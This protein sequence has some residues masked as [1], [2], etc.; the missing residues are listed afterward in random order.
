M[1]NQIDAVYTIPGTTPEQ[2]RYRAT[3]VMPKEYTDIVID[4]YEKDIQF[5]QIIKQN[6]PDRPVA[7]AYA[8]ND[9]QNI[10]SASL[11]SMF[12]SRKAEQNVVKLMEQISSYLLQE[13]DLL[14][15]YREIKS[16]GKK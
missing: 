4:T 15:G 1:A 2:R 5:D 16:G 9:N 14:E 3:S 13:A 6:F 7:P 12:R 10:Q 11:E 8:Q